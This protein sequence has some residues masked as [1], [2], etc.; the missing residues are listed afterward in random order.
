V[1]D[2]ATKDPQALLPTDILFQT[3][4]WARVKA[5]LGSKP[6]AYDIGAAEQ[7]GDVLV[8]IQSSGQGHLHASV[9]QGPEYAP[10]PE[11]Y[12]VFLESLSQCLAKSLDP[13]VSFI[14]YDLPWKSQ[15][16]EEMQELGW[17]AFPEARLQEMRM[18]MGTR[19][20]NLRKASMDMT[21]ASSLVLD[22][23]SPKEEIISRMRPK[24]RYNIRLARRKGVEVC[25]ASVDRLPAFYDLYCQTALRNGFPS[26]SYRNFSALFTRQLYDPRTSEVLFLL[27]HHGHDLL[28][29]ALVAISE[30]TAYFLYGASADAK[31][32][33]MGSYALQWKA[34]QLAR[35]RGCLIYDMGGIAPGVD[36]AH[37]FYGL[38]RFKT[39][40][41]GS[42]VLRSGTWDYPLDHNQY[43]S[44]CTAERLSGN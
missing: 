19:L 31:R 18:N 32:N 25:I 23:E 26:S 43:A 40:F 14:R 2:L 34:I 13:K 36:P 4:Y 22:I 38:Y 17:A 9:P 11:E 29:G 16:A 1:L 39:G 21:V 15:Y 5:D 6:Y 8:L 24:T 10:D 28:A 12:G 41:G 35:E 37:P 30:K 42:V 7:R 20:W 3:G 44:F 33:H 27:A